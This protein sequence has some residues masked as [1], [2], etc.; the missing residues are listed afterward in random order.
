MAENAPKPPTGLSKPGRDL[1][2]KV[3]GV[4]DF[5]D[6]RELVALRQSCLLEDDLDRLRTELATAA[7]VVK[8][9]TGQPVE[10]PLLGAIR[11]AVALQAKL[12]GSIGI[13]NS[14]ASASHAGRALVGQRWGASG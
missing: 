4:L 3:T 8:G 11:N 1:W 6:P 5:D 9:S 7:L 12:L 14:Q 2:R 13:D 10:T